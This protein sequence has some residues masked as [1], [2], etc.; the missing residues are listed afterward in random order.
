MDLHKHDLSLGDQLGTGGQGTV[1][2]L[3]GKGKGL[4]YKEYLNP[5]MVNGVELAELV[6]LPSRAFTDAE[7]RR[8][9]A[10]TAWPRN[11]VLDGGVVKGFLMER[12]P[13]EFSGQ[14]AAG[15]K[16]LELQYLLYP[17]KPLWGSITPLDVDGRLH[18]VRQAA[19][20]FQ[21]LHSKGLVIGDVSMVNLLWSHTPGIHLLDC[22]GIRRQGHPPVTAQAET[23]DWDDPTQPPGG[24]DLDTDRYKLALLVVRV[25]ARDSGVR[26][27]QAP[28]LLPG[29]PQRIVEEVTKR[30]AEAN[31]PR[32]TRP[33]AARWCAA[34]SERG[35]ITLGPL[36]PPR[37]PPNLPK[38]P[39]DLPGPRGTIPLPPR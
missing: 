24:P 32:G 26:P 35:T 1:F 7:R 8:L 5:G 22:D 2:A 31:G 19:A 9:R 11:R 36:P 17:P 20:L 15:A 28:T 37:Q 39:V 30:F 6:A 4:V 34:L 3:K 10:Q 38:A 27:L 25:L 12:V 14:A 18:A 29:L 13:D 16:L 23:P 21:L 33:D